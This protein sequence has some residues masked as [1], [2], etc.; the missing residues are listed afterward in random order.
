MKESYVYKVSF[1]TGHYYYGWHPLRDEGTYCGSPKTNKHFWGQFEFSVETV[2]YFDTY[3]EAQILETR[4]LKHL[5]DKDPMCLNANYGGRVKRE[6]LVEQ[7]E[8]NGGKNFTNASSHPGVMEARRRN[9]RNSKN[10]VSREK[11]VQGGRTAGQLSKERGTGVHAMSREE[12]QKYWQE[13]LEGWNSRVVL[14]I[15]TGEVFDS[16]SEAGR[17]MGVSGT[18]IGN[19]IRKGRTSCGKRWI[20]LN[21]YEVK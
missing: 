20:Y 9:G 16:I 11:L 2:Q 14:C 4:I 8:R 18:A 1:E 12:R 7:G 19:A 5:V 13:N 21:D 3:E 17:A 15:D 10:R 6:I